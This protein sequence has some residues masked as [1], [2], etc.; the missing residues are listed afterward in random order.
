MATY[1]QGRRSSRQTGNEV[2][3]SPRAIVDSVFEMAG[4]KGV[5]IDIALNGQDTN[6][7]QS[8]T[9]LDRLEGH[10]SVTSSTKTA[11]DEIAISFE[12]HSKTWIEKLAPTVAT[13]SRSEAH[14]SFLSLT[15]PINQDQYPQPRMLMP[16]ETYKFPFTFVIPPRMPPGCHHKYE[17]DQI[18]DAHSELPPS[19]GDHNLA[20][21]GQILLDDMA[22]DMAKIWYG[23]HAVVI[24]RRER[25]GKKLQCAEVMKKVRVIPAVEEHA[26]VNA[27][28]KSKDYRLR[29][30]KGL[31]KGILK[32]KLGRIVME[33]TQPRDLRQ[34]SPSSTPES[35]DALVTTG[36]I[37]QLRFDPNDE[38]AQP[39]K[40][41]QLSSKLK[42]NTWY[43]TVGMKDFPVAE[44]AY[45]DGNRGVYPDHVNLSSRAVQAVQW[46]RHDGSESQEPRRTA[47]YAST[48]SN[49][50]TPTGGMPEP[51]KAYRGS[52]FFTAE[53]KVPISL[54]K[55]KYFPPTFFSC[56]VAR[57]YQLEIGL[58]LNTPGIGMSPTLE[59]RVPIQVSSSQR[60]GNE[61]ALE[62]PQYIDNDD[63]LVPRQFSSP[64]QIFAENYS[65]PS[66][67]RQSV[68]QSGPALP[69]AD[70]AQSQSEPPPSFDHPGNAPPGYS[71]FDGASHGVPVR[72]P[73]P[74]GISPGCG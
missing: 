64:P 65:L 43:S 16:G 39:P 60:F 25:D 71:F 8:F 41:N 13:S 74:L 69:G 54:P 19:F 35:K 72:I 51:S 55:C 18:R 44:T 22:P 1:K 27:E 62:S 14:H 23:I 30:E 37:V 12:G 63:P 24:R 70:R 56:L 28:F 59:V 10:V 31:S 58:S 68:S 57:I 38:S 46:K 4:K 53:I 26:P 40:L 52:I 73:S 15:Q 29:S 11:F 47:S 2:F 45:M 34:P 3:Y 32:G 7:V 42:V 66:S 49:F 33:A 67:P 61:P 48:D 21:N 5:Q 6:F 50:Q 36:T 9:T 20:G 17:S